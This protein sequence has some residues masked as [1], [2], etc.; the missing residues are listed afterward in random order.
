MYLFTQGLFFLLVGR[1]LTAVT[2]LVGTAQCC[3]SGSVV[4]A[5]GRDCSAACGIFPDQG[6]N[7][8][9]Q[10]WQV[11]SHPLGHREVLPG[12]FLRLTS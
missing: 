5:H 6:L 9:P 2:S 11:D 12:Y 7:P 10:H 4:V 8:G 1:L 3:G